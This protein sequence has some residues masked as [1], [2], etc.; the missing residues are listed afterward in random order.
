MKKYKHIVILGSSYKQGK[1]IALDFYDNLDKFKSFIEKINKE[2]KNKKIGLPIATHVLKINSKKWED[3]QKDDQFFKGVELME[4]E[5][6]FINLLIEDDSISSLDIANYLLTKTKCTHTKLHKILYFLYADYLVQYGEKLFNDEIYA[7]H[8][9]PVVKE[10]FSKYSTLKPDE[11]ELYNLDENVIK[12]IKKELKDPIEARILITNLGVEKINFIDKNFAK[13]NNASTQTLIDLTHKPN[14]PWSKRFDKN[15]LSNIITDD[16]IKE[17]H[18]N[19][20]L[21]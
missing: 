15:H 2:G 1:R 8:Y 19:E 11:F 17:F 13:Y 20:L 3:V 10:V 14:T 7:F 4:D 18:K 16:D 21:K 9:G 5:D 6:K 12:L